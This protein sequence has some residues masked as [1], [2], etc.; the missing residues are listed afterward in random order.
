M[1][2]FLY[3][4]YFFILNFVLI[5]PVFAVSQVNKNIVIKS[6][7]AYLLSFDEQILKYKIGNEEAISVEIVH[8]LYPDENEM[9]INAKKNI[10]TNLLIWTKTKEY[11]F[12][13][14][15]SENKD[16]AN[17]SSNCIMNFD[18]ENLEL[19]KEIKPLMN[20]MK[21]DQPPAPCEETGTSIDQ[22]PDK[23]K[24]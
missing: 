6:G 8:S 16:A 5:T 23:V 9:V 11:N 20:N 4:V 2:K 17:N 21:F 10:N 15:T 14:N 18:K 3:L 12:N 13:I 24:K 7:Y 22:P 19:K 1:K